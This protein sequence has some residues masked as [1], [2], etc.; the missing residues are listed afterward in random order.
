MQ[1]RSVREG[2]VDRILRIFLSTLIKEGSLEIE[3]A[4][5][6][7]FTVG[8]GSPPTA[9]VRFCDP[10]AAYKFL[11]NPGLRFGELFMN[12]QVQVTRGTIYDVLSIGSRNVRRFNKF[13][14]LRMI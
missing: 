3:T 7:R 13:V 9:G 1:P 12:G 6:Q 5:G 8:D 4:S 2:Q 10:S 11:L 14:W